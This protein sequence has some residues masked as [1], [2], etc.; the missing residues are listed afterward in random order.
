MSTIKVTHFV[1]CWCY[2]LV[3]LFYMLILVAF[4]IKKRKNIVNVLGN[5]ISNMVDVMDTAR[6]SKKV[7]NSELNSGKDLL[8]KEKVD[9]IESDKVTI[10]KEAVK[11]LDLN[12]TA[13]AYTGGDGVEPPL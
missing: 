5:S 7:V 4:F 3:V 8:N 10:S 9:S 12:I 1:L 6:E 2:L 13:R 11:K